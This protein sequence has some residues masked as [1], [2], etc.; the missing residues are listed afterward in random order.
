MTYELDE[1]EYPCD[2]RF[3]AAVSTLNQYLKAYNIAI[4]K[5]FG[6]DGLE[7]IAQIWADM[8]E[9]FFPTSFEAMG[10]E[11]DG[12][13]EIAE[14]FAKADAVMGYDTD[15]FVLSENKAGFRINK[16]PWFEEPSPEGEQICSKGVIAFEKRAAKLLNPEI[17]VSLG[18]FFHK[19]DACCE[20]I[21]EIPE[22]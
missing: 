1:N 5:K 22:K 12:P 18:K 9:R 3:K 17:K 11:G 21:F 13:K 2:R 14:W 8:A 6:E 19:G 4:Y 15:L 7:L 20:Y 16:C 10:L